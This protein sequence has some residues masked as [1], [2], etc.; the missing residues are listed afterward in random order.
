MTAS[1]AFALAA[2]SKTGVR[3]SL[4]NASFE[5][6]LAFA[7]NPDRTFACPEMQ[8][9]FGLSQYRVYNLIHRLVKDGLIER[10]GR[11]QYRAS[12][13]LRRMVRMHSPGE[14]A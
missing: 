9:D 6:A 7:L 4:E 14:G 10:V 8:D 11:G 12:P 2:A 13:A 3:P 1:P 5:F